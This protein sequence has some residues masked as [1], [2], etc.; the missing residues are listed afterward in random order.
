[1]GFFEFLSGGHEMTAKG[2]E[3]PLGALTELQKIRLRSAFEDP[4]TSKEYLQRVGR[5][6]DM[7]AT[8]GRDTERMLSEKLKGDLS[9]G[10][11]AQLML[12]A[13][14][15]RNKLKAQAEGEAFQETVKNADEQ[16]ARMLDILSRYQA[17]IFSSEVASIRET[18]GL[19]DVLNDAAGVVGSFYGVGSMIGRG[20]K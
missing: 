8:S 12:G 15:E 14:N 7:F 4:R 1:M 18:N 16:Y 5:I 20:G 19:L 17:N 9:S 2:P 13:T 11:F 6:G 3:A 10:G